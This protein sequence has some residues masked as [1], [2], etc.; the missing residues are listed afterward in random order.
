M[1]IVSK[2]IKAAVTLI[3][4]EFSRLRSTIKDYECKLANTYRQNANLAKEIEALKAE[5]E[6]LK[7]QAA[8]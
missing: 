4:E 6:D 7:N 8:Q 3:E 5:I 1:D 2:I